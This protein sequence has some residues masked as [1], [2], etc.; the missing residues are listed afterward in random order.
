MRLRREEMLYKVLLIIFSLVGIASFHATNPLTSTCLD[1]VFGRWSAL[2]VTL[3]GK[4]DDHAVIGNEVLDGDLSLIGKDRAAARSSV[5]FSD[6]KKLILDDGQH[7]RFTGEDVEEVLDFLEDGIVFHL[8]LVLLHACKL[9]KAQLK[10]GI[11]LAVSEY[12]G[13]I[14]HTGL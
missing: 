9:V 10:D 13:V 14:L 5:L 7:T 11:D 4:C 8:H 6:F 1:T 12:V 3:I 2:N